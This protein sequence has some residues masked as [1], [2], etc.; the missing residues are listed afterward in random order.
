MGREELYNR[1][2]SGEGLERGG[3]E[4]GKGRE[5]ALSVSAR[6]ECVPPSSI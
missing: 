3:G 5:E 4:D 2:N 6:P 1:R